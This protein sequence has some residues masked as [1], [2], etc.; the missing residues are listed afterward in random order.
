MSPQE[1][2]EILKLKDDDRSIEGLSHP[3]RIRQPV[4][5]RVRPRVPYSEL[6]VEGVPSASVRRVGGRADRPNERMNVC[7]RIYPSP[8]SHPSPRSISPP[9]LLLPYLLLYPTL[10][11]YLKSA[12]ESSTKWRGRCGVLRGVVT[13]ERGP[14]GAGARQSKAG[15]SASWP[16]FRCARRNSDQSPRSGRTRQ[17]TTAANMEV[18]GSFS[19]EDDRVAG[20]ARRL[21]HELPPEGSENA[22]NCQRNAV[23]RQ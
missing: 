14:I 2:I 6:A 22:L 15:S 17:H 16:P 23:K 13:S 20:V 3:L 21:L 1:S 4:V 7:G 9:P 12:A 18:C 19:R 5:P 8:S 11:I 10:S